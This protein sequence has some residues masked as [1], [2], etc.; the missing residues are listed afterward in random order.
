MFHCIIVYGA[1]YN[2]VLD[3]L[4]L[5]SLRNRDHVIFLTCWWST[6][7]GLAFVYHFCYYVDSGQNKN[8]HC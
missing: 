7:W 8:E 5:G 3:L 1:I 2:I 4:V 6:I